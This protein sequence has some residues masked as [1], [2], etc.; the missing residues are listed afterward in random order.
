MESDIHNKLRAHSDEHPAEADNYDPHLIPA[1]TAA[2]KEREK[3]AYKQTPAATSPENAADIDTTAGYTS[4]KEG[5]LNNYAIEPEMYYETPGDRTA[6]Q[7]AEEVERAAELHD[8]DDNDETGKLTMEK[9]SR[10]KG[11]GII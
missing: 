4:D 9:D 11:S 3:S 5:L 6:I 1:E 10:G 7:Q 2:R 8:I